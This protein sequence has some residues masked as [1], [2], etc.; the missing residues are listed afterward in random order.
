MRRTLGVV[1][2]AVL[3]AVWLQGCTGIAAPLGRLGITFAVQQACGGASDQEIQSIITVVE[4]AKTK[5]TA[6]DT[7]LSV[8]AK[9][10][11]ADTATEA[12]C[13]TCTT[14]IIDQVYSR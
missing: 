6:K 2:G 8:F 13:L 11:A 12:V 3:L 9:E 7:T 10:C 1:L 5:G 4:G 14:A